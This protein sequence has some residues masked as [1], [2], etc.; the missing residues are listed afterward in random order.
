[1]TDGQTILLKLGD[2]LITDKVK[3]E[4]ALPELILSLLSNLNLYLD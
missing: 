2:S 4:T 3:A 1:M